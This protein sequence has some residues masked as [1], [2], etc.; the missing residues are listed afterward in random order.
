MAVSQIVV[1]ILLVC[2]IF[3]M[4]A[5]VLGKKE[6]KMLTLYVHESRVPPNP[7]LITVVTATGNLSQIGFGSI[8]VFSNVLKDGPS[9]DSTV[10][11]VEPGFVTI[12]KQ[13]IFVSYTFTI[14]G[15]EGN[16]TLAVQ[17]Q[18][19]LNVWPREMAVVGGTGIFRYANGYDISEIV[20]DTNPANYVTIHK[21]YLKFL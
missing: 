20:D 13:N 4:P 3:C 11:G 1:K 15:P 21:I 9:N 17:G 19:A 18:F 7:T 6:E 10:I 12:G 5:L 2:S 14:S 8:Q 16:G